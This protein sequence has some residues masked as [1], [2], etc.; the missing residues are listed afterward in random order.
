[1]SSQTSPFLQ[2]TN[3]VITAYLPAIIGPFN[4]IHRK[5]LQQA[6]NEKKIKLLHHPLSC[7]EAI[8]TLYIDKIKLIECVVVPCDFKSSLSPYHQIM[9]FNGSITI[10]TLLFASS[11]FIIK[12]T[13][14]HHIAD[15]PPTKVAK[16]SQ[17]H[18]V[19]NQVFSLFG[20][21]KNKTA[22]IIMCDIMRILTPSLSLPFF[23]RPPSTTP[24]MQANIMDESF[25]LTDIALLPNDLQHLS[26]S[27]VDTFAAL[28]TG[29]DQEISEPVTTLKDVP[30]TR[31]FKANYMPRKTEVQGFKTMINRP[32]IAGF[33]LTKIS[34]YKKFFSTFPSGI[35]KLAC[36]KDYDI[37]T[38]PKNRWPLPF[39]LFLLN[40]RRF[41]NISRK[42][43]IHKYAVNSLMSISDEEACQ[44]V[45]MIVQPS[46]DSEDIQEFMFERARKSPEFAVHLYFAL[47]VEF[48]NSQSEKFKAIFEKWKSQNSPY[49]QDAEIASNELMKLHAIVKGVKSVSGRE[50]KLNYVKNELSKVKFDRPFRLPISPSFIVHSISTESII[51]FGSSLQPVKM[52]FLDKDNNVYSA[53]LKVG[54]D[55]RQDALAVTTIKFIDE[56]L[57]RFNLDMCVT[58]YAV[59]PISRSF[60]LMEFV[61]GA[62]TISKVLQV[63]NNMIQ[64]YFAGPEEECRERFIKSSAAYTVISYVLGVGDRHLDNLLMKSNGYFFHVDYGFMFGQDPKPLP[65]SV[66]VVG[67]MVAAFDH[68]DTKSGSRQPV[69]QK[70]YYDFLRHC[71]V[72]FNAIRRKADEFCCLIALLAT[73]ELPHLPS[74]DETIAA[75]LL[76][77]LHLDLTEKDA[78][79]KIISEVEKSVKALLPKFYE[80]LHQK[81]QTLA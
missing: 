66:R 8:I 72:V 33:D 15:L 12:I 76:D 3:N 1:M 47:R 44:Y 30:N 45:S 52:D 48:E 43:L 18:I 37:D 70:G 75:I 39:S 59:L 31:L 7:F 80:W 81:R 69:S 60:G 79:K 50:N 28:L 35:L 24:D 6:K 2:D 38:I 17:R 56:N 55:M 22:G 34:A 26:G 41:P 61:V 42:T 11:Q 36:I 77:R 54:D 40:R 10:P 62:K 25:Y 21:S 53:I 16:G 13:L 14:T 20:P 71:A 5:L 68:V 67:E 19:G 4:S 58:H 51:V 57:K 9:I 27:I 49:F 29:P 73:S 32:F 23:T 78:G 64:D 65:C 63:K 74:K 46:R